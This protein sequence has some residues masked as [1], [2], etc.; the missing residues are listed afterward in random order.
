MATDVINLSAAVEL[1]LERIFQT[2][3][4]QRKRR[5]DARRT[6]PLVRLWDGDWKFGGIV[7]GENEGTMTWVKNDTGSCILKLPVHHHL[8]QWVLDHQGRET[9]NI[10]LTV[11]K[12]G[13]RWSGRLRKDLLKKTEE[14][15]RFVELQFLHDYEEV[16]RIQ[17]WSNPFLPAAIQFPRVSIL[18]GPAKWVLKTM[19]L[20]NV[21]RLNTSLWHLPDDPLDPAS[22]S[23]AFNPDEWPIVVKPGSLLEDDSPWTIASSRFKFWH[24]MAAPTLEDAEL[25]VECRRFLDGDEPPWPGATLRN[26]TLVIDIVDKS[27]RYSET[28]AGTGGNI[29][30]GFI[31]TITNLAENL[32]DEDE[33]IVPN[34]DMP[35]AYKRKD[36]L[37]TLP[38]AP[39]VTYRD[40]AI[41]GVEAAEFV[42]EP[43]QAV[44][45]NAGGHSMPGVNEGIS[46]AVQLAGNNLGMF[47]FQPTA[48][49]IIDTLLKPIY[50]DT[51]LAW[52]SI[53]SP[54]RSR[55]AGWS[56][57]H[58]HFAKG[59]DRAYT[60]SGLIAMREGF[61]ETRARTSH[62]LKVADG[63]PWFIG[64]NGLGHFFL[65]DRIGSTIIGL[66]PDRLVV[67]QVSDLTFSWSREGMGWEIAVGDQQAAESPTSRSIRKLSELIS[68][69]HDQGVL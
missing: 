34:P 26:G 40:G 18:A 28:G 69:V 6:P 25:M 33:T 51:I 63:A 45:V 27:G 11:D 39:F 20:M 53:K 4:G 64:E 62:K 44:Q 19:L 12:D 55:R 9:E 5:E 65:G 56:H 31:R 61:W 21:V 38:Q 30:T 37:G 48:G 47:V 22:W 2:C 49:T 43:A 50:S 60:L 67:E 17:C 1:E 7:A 16:K 10:H 35:D 15:Q 3:Q 36:W 29:F 42:H 52:M 41:T 32:I 24:D 59:G 66:P 14:G 54:I 46:A 68:T 58:E 57:Y 8:S 13:A 23:Q